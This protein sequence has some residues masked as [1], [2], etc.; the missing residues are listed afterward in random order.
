[1]CSDG[2]LESPVDGGTF[3]LEGQSSDATDVQILLSGDSVVENTP[4]GT[5]VGKTPNQC[6][7][8][9]M[10]IETKN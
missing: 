4:A 9:G 7:L 2:V 5:Q 10:E 1:M 8:V 3:L 6:Q